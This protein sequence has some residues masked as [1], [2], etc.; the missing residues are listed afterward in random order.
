[1]SALEV[2]RAQDS[3]KEHANAIVENS[4]FKKTRLTLHT[5]MEID[6]DEDEVDVE[7]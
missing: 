6:E 3:K 7:L 1:M 5:V 2:W 4:K